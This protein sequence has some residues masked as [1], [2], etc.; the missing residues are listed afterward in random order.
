[1]HFTENE[2]DEEDQREEVE[3]EE[4]EE[5]EEEEGREGESIVSWEEEE[6]EEDPYNMC[7]PDQI[8]DTVDEH[9]GYIPDVT[10]RPP[11]PIPRPSVTSQPE[12]NK[13]Y[14]SRG[15]FIRCTKLFVDLHHGYQAY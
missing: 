11:A 3:G 15:E 6:E 8:Y 13:T 12:D 4:E 14:I 7:F 2:E 1:M 10:N 5:A 9:F